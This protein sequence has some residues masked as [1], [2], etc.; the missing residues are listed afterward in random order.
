MNDAEEG[1]MAR[2]RLRFIAYVAAL[3]LLA[4]AAVPAGAV[5]QT[6]PK[7]VSA[8]TAVPNGHTYVGAAAR[9]PAHPPGLFVRESGVFAAPLVA[10]SLQAGAPRAWWS[11]ALG[12]TA[13]GR[14]SRSI[15]P[16]DGHA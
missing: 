11:G 16:S 10:P 2:L 15:S 13:S 4:L 3:A 5:S 1:Y 8:T 6:Q 9:S 12:V 7:D 14:G